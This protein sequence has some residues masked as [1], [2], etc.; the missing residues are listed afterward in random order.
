MALAAGGQESG[1]ALLLVGIL[2]SANRLSI[3][4]NTWSSAILSGPAHARLF[5]RRTVA[6]HDGVNG[7]GWAFSLW[8][9]PMGR[10]PVGVEAGWYQAVWTADESGAGRLMGLVG[11]DPTGQRVQR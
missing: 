5:P 6:F 8:R 3:G 1:I 7:V 9:A 4:S 10:R 11:H 2:L